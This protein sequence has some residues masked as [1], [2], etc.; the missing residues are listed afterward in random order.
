[1]QKAKQ[2]FKSRA[3]RAEGQRRFGDRRRVK[4][5]AAGWESQ[6]RVVDEAREHLH[7]GAGDFA[8]CMLWDL[9]TEGAGLELGDRTVTVGDRVELDLPLGARRR[10]TIKL[11]CE[12]RHASDD[13]RGSPRAGL[14]FI[15]VGD[16][17]R[18]LLLRLL[19]DL[20]G[21]ASRSA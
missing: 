15:D 2:M 17:E 4:R 10:A 21:A 1:V 12:V 9:S 11:K 13:G 5:Q 14:E 8:P 3:A 6:Y 19:R 18:A 20:H 16:L 7:F